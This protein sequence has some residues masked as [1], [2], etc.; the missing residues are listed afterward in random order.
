MQID[1]EIKNLIIFRRKQ[2]IVVSLFKEYK[3]VY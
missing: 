2:S 3:Y 1:K